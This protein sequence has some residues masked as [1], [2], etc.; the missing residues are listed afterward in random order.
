MSILSFRLDGPLIVHVVCL[1]VFFFL[2]FSLSMHVSWDDCVW[3]TLEDSDAKRC[4]E[5][6]WPCCAPRLIG[7]WMLVLA[8]FLQILGL[9]CAL[10]WLMSH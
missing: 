5:N 1:F 10:I 4:S 2:C 9:Y 6:L 3:R 8:V 7:F